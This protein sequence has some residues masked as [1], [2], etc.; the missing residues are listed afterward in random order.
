MS[1]SVKFEMIS[2]GSQSNK[3]R[4]T[5]G[6]HSVEVQAANKKEGKQVASQELLSVRNS[7]IKII[8]IRVERTCVLSNYL[9]KF[10]CMSIY[11]TNMYCKVNFENRCLLFNEP[12]IF[13]NLY[14][15]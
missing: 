14:F 7:L 6:A 15:L 4:L 12:F 3:F 10:I 1:N 2:P 9:F 13:L 5:V 8:T 11:L